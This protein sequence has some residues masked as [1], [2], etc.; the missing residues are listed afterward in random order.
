MSVL[1]RVLGAATAAY[2]L[3]TI[4]YP[5]A[6][7]KPCGLTTASGAVPAGTRTLIAAMGARDIAIGLAM[8]FA[9][10]GKPMRLALAARVA[11]DTADAA[12]FGLGLPDRSARPKAAAAALGWAALC[13]VSTFVRR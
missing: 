4:V 1:T 11:S 6:L 7:A 13:A 2:G 8:A 10:E 9:D 5:R 12:A 3:T